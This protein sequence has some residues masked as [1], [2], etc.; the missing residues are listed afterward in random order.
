MATKTYLE[1]VNDV[2]V[3]LREAQVGSVATNSYST[4]IGKYVNDAKRMVEDAWDWESLLTSIDV[5]ILVG[6][7]TYT[8]STLNER[9][10]L[11]KTV[12]NPYIPMAFDTTSGDKF[13]LLLRPLDW[14]LEQVNLQNI[15][16]YQDKPIFF[17]IRKL[18]GGVSIFLLETPTATRT[19]TL[20]FIDPSD[21][22]SADSDVLSIPYAPVVQI[23]LDY[24]L[25]ERGEE[26]GEP[27][28]TVQQKAFT[29]IANAV[30]IDAQEQTHKTTFYP[31]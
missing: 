28:T 12:D 24:A 16:Q 23:A 5:P 25:N 22:L 9:A 15:P 6:T 13:Q 29:H 17:A 30:A 4:L 8:L 2:L 7:L 19:W 11:L 18:P 21:D 10:R 1:L 27:G 20:Y 3:R 26:I 31:G 14:V